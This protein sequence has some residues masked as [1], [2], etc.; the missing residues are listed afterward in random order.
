MIKYNWDKIMR[1]TEGD[2]AS[3]LTIIHILTYNRLPYSKNDP[4]YKYYGKDFIGNSF[5]INPEKL[6]VERKNYSNVE[7]SIYIM[8]ASYRNYLYY[9]NTG[10]TSLELI[11]LPFVEKIINTNRLLRM[12]DGVIHFKFEDNAK[13]KQNGNKI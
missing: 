10:R 5:L 3:V 11:H 12:E 8:V 13:E 4:T 6:L 7:A 1:T 2:P 9:K